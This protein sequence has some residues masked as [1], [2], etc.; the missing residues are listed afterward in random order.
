MPAPQLTARRYAYICISGPGK[1]ETITERLGLMPTYACNVGD[2]NEKNGRPH[3]F[4]RWEFRSGLDDTHPLE[5]HIQQLLLWFNVKAEA[6]R[7]LWVEY[8]L[9]L[10]C[11]GHF[12][13]SHGPGVHFNREVIRQAGQLGLAID[14]DFYFTEDHGHDG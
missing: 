12:P 2:I 9:T 4:M 8:D 5:Q 7:G 10:Q 6:V 3:K 11:V 1:H 13:L 14:C